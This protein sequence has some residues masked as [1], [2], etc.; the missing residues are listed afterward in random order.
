MPENSQQ[1]HVN[2]PVGPKCSNGLWQLVMLIICTPHREHHG[3]ETDG[4]WKHLSFNFNFNLAVVGSAFCRD[5]S[6]RNLQEP[7]RPKALPTAKGPKFQMHYAPGTVSSKGAFSEGALVEID[8]PVFCPSGAD[9]KF[10]AS[11]SVPAASLKVP[12][13]GLVC[14]FWLSM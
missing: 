10:G 3:M 4:T 9:G 8:V 6:C 7:P 5:D 2:I 12:A 11:L 13:R 14:S 1:L